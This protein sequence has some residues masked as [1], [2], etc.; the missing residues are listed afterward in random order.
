MKKKK[1]L[2]EF[3]FEKFPVFSFLLSS[4]LSFIFARLFFHSLYSD[5]VVRRVGGGSNTQWNVKYEM[6]PLTLMH[7]HFSSSHP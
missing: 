5:M 1:N 6:K 2:C 7:N 3:L 4:L